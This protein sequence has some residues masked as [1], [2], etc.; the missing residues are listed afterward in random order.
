MVSSTVKSEY[1]EP[2]L[3]RSWYWFRVTD[4]SALGLK[5][6]TMK[7]EID[8]KELNARTKLFISLLGKKSDASMTRLYYAIRSYDRD[9]TIMDE[10]VDRHGHVKDVIPTA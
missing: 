9:D 2:F 10:A 3:P 4:P 8:Q 1:Q 7:N 5:S 6:R